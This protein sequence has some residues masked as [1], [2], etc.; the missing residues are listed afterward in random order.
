M[1]HPRDRRARRAQQPLHA[2]RALSSAPTDAECF[3]NAVDDDRGRA[4]A[5]S[6]E[7][8]RLQQESTR[9][10]HI[11]ARRRAR[12]SSDSRY[13]SSRRRA[14]REP[15]PRRHH[16]RCCEGPGAHVELRGLFAPIGHAASRRAHA[17]RSRRAAHDQR[18]GLSRHRRRPRP[19]RVQRQGH[20]AAGCAEDRRAP[21]EPQPAALAD[22]GD[23]HQAGARDLRERR[24]VQS[25]RDDRPARCDRPLLP[26]LARP[27]RG[28]GARRC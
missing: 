22:R 20:R 12:C 24:E 18:R 28:R 19:R 14:R 25:R 13:V 4:R 21:V 9:S 2:D 6:V 7:H 11:G 27:V 26:A 23:R 8:Y 15:G 17:H 5:R 10:F 16:R 3:T 1:S